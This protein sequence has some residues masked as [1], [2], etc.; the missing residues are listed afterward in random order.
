[1]AL[2]WAATRL[3]SGLLYG[4]KPSDPFTLAY[5]SVLLAGIGLIAS[6]VTACRAASIDPM[7]ALRTEKEL[8]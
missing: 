3:L 7:V 1:L 6:V 2:D 8:P 4:V 5:V